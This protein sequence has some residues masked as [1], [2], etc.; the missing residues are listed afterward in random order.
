MVAIGGAVL[1]ISLE[2]LLAGGQ[3]VV[4]FSLVFGSAVV[5][6]GVLASSLYIQADSSAVVVGTILTKRRY[7]RQA[8]ASIRASH[9]PMAR[10]THFLRS[11]G[12]VIFVTSGYLWGQDR[13]RLLANYLGVPL[14]W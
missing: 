3:A 6:C 11:D 12:S 7:D 2:D 14:D 8:I 13:L 1:W 9:S 10:I 5:A 4:W